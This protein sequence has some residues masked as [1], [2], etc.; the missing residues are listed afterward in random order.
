MKAK[1]Q[2][3]N[4]NYSKYE[5]LVRFSV[6]IIGKISSGKSTILNF[7]LDLKEKLQVKTNTTIRFVCLIRHNKLLKN[8]DP[9]IYNVEFIPRAVDYNYYNF[10][11][12][13][14]IEGDI[15]DIIQKRNEDLNNKIIDEIP[16]NYFYII[17]NFIPFFEGEYEKYADYFEFLDVPGLN[18]VSNNLNIDNIYYEKVLPLIYNNIK[19]SIFVFE[20]KF[21]Q[22]ENSINLYKKYI[23]KLKS[24]NI[25]YFDDKKRINNNQINSIYILNKIDLCDKQGGIKQEKI[26][27][28]KYL[29]EKLQVDLNL[30]KMILLNSKDNILEKNK[31]K[32]FDNYLYYLKRSK[33]NNDDFIKILI[34]NLKKDLNIQIIPNVN[35]Y[36][37]DDDEDDSL[38][39]LKINI[40]SDII[41]IGM[42][43]SDYNYY[44]NIFDINKEKI[45]KNKE[46][47]ELKSLILNSIKSTYNDFINIDKFKEL[48][49]E[50]QDKIIQNKSQLGKKFPNISGKIFGDKNYLLTLEKIG[51]VCKQLKEIEPEHEYINQIY[52]NYLEVKKYIEKEYKFKIALLGGISSGKSSIINSLIGYDLNLIPKS[53]DDCTK[54][55]LIIHYTESQ[56]DISLYKTK[57]IK[58][59]TNIINYIIF[60]KKKVI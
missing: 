21:Y 25:D 49:K 50:I 60:L 2:D 15:K 18:E 30:N 24:R 36:D 51:E 48:E 38:M 46:N 59:K 14:L 40:N 53:S 33:S 28:K 41:E 8:K 57:I 44:K 11:K 37:D 29:E 6:P 13:N 17:E 20:T 12:G 42:N 26:D 4:L 58:N 27:F 45:K 52:N 3:F 35:N 47:N 55:I 31:Y 43:K 1:I 34:E 39:K 56:D 7:I 16:E 22:T 5:N 19:F 32:D 9:L 54:I 10:E 23:N